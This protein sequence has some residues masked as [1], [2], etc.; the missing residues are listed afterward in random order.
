MMDIVFTSEVFSVEN[1]QSCYEKSQRGQTG[2]CG[3]LA[4]V[5]GFSLPHVLPHVLATQPLGKREKSIE[6]L[7]G[8]SLLS[9]QQVE[10]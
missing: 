7:F 8:V 4:S 6:D 9:T 2:L 1:W 3:L 10:S 5:A